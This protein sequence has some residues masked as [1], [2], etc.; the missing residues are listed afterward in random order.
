M[1][2]KFLLLMMVIAIFV[3]CSNDAIRQESITSRNLPQDSARMPRDRTEIEG[4]ETFYENL[5]AEAYVSLYPQLF[6]NYLLKENMY[7]LF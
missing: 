5:D 1:N 7:R 2:N 4:W 6:G 3:S